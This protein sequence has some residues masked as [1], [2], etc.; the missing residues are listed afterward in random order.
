MGARVR[1][2][3]VVVV[4]LLVGAFVGSAWSQRR[5]TRSGEAGSAAGARPRVRVRVEVLN[6]GGSQG[7]A[8]D[9]TDRLRDQGFDVVFY[10]NA[11]SFGRDS[12]MVLDRTDHLDEA[13]AVADALGIRKVRSE[14]DSNLYLDVS[15]LLGRDWKP[16]SASATSPV[17]ERA[18]WDPRRWLKR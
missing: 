2:V 12:S 6:A 4:V 1:T 9:A 7:A 11:K 14:P 18:W 13:R 5:S 16:P 17:A 3:A 10:G 15:V 8:R